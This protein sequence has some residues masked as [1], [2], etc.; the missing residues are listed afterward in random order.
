[1]CQRRRGSSNRERRG[2][3]FRDGEVLVAAK[4]APSTILPRHTTVSPH[5]L[6]ISSSLGTSR[7]RAPA[8]G[9]SSGSSAS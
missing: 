1:M 7:W 8:R 2:F 9:P 5:P 4:D 3:L 6:I